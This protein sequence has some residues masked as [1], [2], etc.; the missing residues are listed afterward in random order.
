MT[1]THTQSAPPAWL[2]RNQRVF[3][4]QESARKALD[5]LRLADWREGRDR[6]HDFTEADRHAHDIT[7]AIADLVAL[8]LHIEDD[9]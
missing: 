6:T 9:S 7:D 3:A 4:A 2:I 1:D 5:A 8:A